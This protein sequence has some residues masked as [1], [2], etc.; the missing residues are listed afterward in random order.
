[1][2]PATSAS[3]ATF[4]PPFRFMTG[5]EVRIHRE[6]SRL[7]L[8]D[9]AGSLVYALPLDHRPGASS[10]AEECLR[11]AAGR[12]GWIIVEPGA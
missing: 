1:M 9:R 12:N 10:A 3:P 11:R 4:H 5:C 6:K 8:R 7:E 2:K